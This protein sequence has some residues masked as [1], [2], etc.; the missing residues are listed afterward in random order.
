MNATSFELFPRLPYPSGTIAELWG[1]VSE[2]DWDDDPVEHILRTQVRAQGLERWIDPDAIRSGGRP[3]T[4]ELLFAEADHH[5]WYAVVRNATHAPASFRV[6]HDGLRRFAGLVRS[7]RLCAPETVEQAWSF[8]GE[9][10]AARMA[11][12][13]SAS[14]WP[15]IPNEPGIVRLGHACLL[16]RSRT[17]SVLID[18]ID[19]SGMPGFDETRLSLGPIDAILITHA[20]SDH[21]H[22]PSILWH[23]GHAEVPVVVPG[24]SV[25]N[26]LTHVSFGTQLRAVGQRVIEARWDTTLEIG[27]LTIDVLP[28][29]GEQP[30]VDVD[31][32]PEP[33]RNWGNVYRIETEEGSVC[34]LCDS[35]QDPSGSVQ[36]VLASSVAHRG[37]PT[38][39]LGCMRE[40]FPPFFGGLP[41]D[42]LAV[43]WTV[44]R[45]LRRRRLDGTL[46]NGTAGPV[47]LAHA[48][49]AA[50]IP[51]FAPYANGY[52]GWQR[53]ITDV[54]WGQGEPSE[55][56]T[57]TRFERAIAAA[58]GRTH[59]IAWKSGD[60]I[61]LAAGRASH[62][63]ISP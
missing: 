28:F 43:P 48:C 60:W 17:T 57:L 8:A 10:T 5:D 52:E 45:E 34:V 51:Y 30:T 39:A 2:V 6:A 1:R 53:P 20:H 41:Q 16:V 47:G 49:L 4:A 40:F 26:L 63:R 7:T 27:D 59:A 15:E 31:A 14:R 38:V 32:I 19:T 3:A 55:A 42:W 9:A 24:N 21:F 35:G 36:D 44:T 56:E 33:I 18:P 58:G 54:G 46:A 12:T 23:A 62:R 37:P 50:D 11:A 29:R 25:P 22:L 13:V 61:S